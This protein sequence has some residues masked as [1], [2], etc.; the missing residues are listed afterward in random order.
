VARSDTP[1]FRTALTGAEIGKQVLRGV[2]RNDL[3]ILTHP[4]IR[5]VLDARAAAL[6]AA[7]PPATVA[8]ARIEAQSRL[9]DASLY[10][11][12]PSYGTSAPT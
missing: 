12:P 3:Y 6:L 11:A 9:L 10:G 8:A 2:R 5:P 7:L 1:I 4:E